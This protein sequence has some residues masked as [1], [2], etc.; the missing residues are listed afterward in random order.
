MNSSDGNGRAPLTTETSRS[1]RFGDKT[2]V[3]LPVPKDLGGENA[4]SFPQVRLVVSRP[5]AAPADLAAHVLPAALKI[6]EIA[7]FVN[8]ETGDLDK[9]VLVGAADQFEIMRTDIGVR[10][11]YQSGST[12]PDV[13]YLAVKLH[14]RA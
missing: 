7:F 11:Q 8:G 10:C 3:D 2:L 12:P 1:T 5:G 4:T 6:V 13:R 9:G 14:L